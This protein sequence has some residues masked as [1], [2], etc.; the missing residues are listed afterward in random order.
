MLQYSVGSFSSFPSTER[1][2][3]LSVMLIG[4]T[5]PESKQ[6]ETITKGP[7]SS[8]IDESANDAYRENPY[9][10]LVCQLKNPWAPRGFRNRQRGAW[11]QSGPPGLQCVRTESLGRTAVLSFG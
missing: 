6:P 3:S 7:P 10:C 5:S 2:F 8:T 11:S 4:G 9:L 1:P